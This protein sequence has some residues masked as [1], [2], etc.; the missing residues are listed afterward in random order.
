[1]KQLLDLT[2]NTGC[3]IISPEKYKQ[4]LSDLVFVPALDI[5]I[6]PLSED[7]LRFQAQLKK[8]MSESAGRESFLSFF[9][10][11]FGF[12]FVDLFCC[13]F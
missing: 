11:L 7:V 9:F 10:F 3:S 13:V 4:E 1:L 6:A 12:V 2:A 8:S 5:R